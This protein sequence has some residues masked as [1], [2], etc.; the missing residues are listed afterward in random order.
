MLLLPARGIDSDALTNSQ[1][2]PPTTT[3]VAA[4]AATAGTT[5]TVAAAAAPTWWKPS[6]TLAFN[7]QLGEDFDVNRHVIPGV[8][9]YAIDWETPAT[10]VAAMLARG[11]KPI[12][13]F[14][15]GT[16]EDWRPDKADFPPQVIGNALDEWPGESWLD[17]R[18]DAVRAIMAKVSCVVVCFV[19]CVCLLLHN[20]N[21]QH[22]A[23]V[24]TN[25]NT[26][27]TPPK[28]TTTTKRIAACK[29]KGFVAVDPDSVD[30]Y[31]NDPGFPLTAAD[32]LAYNRW[33]ADAAHAAGLAAGL[34]NALDLI[35]PAVAAK[36]DF[37]VNEQCFQYNECGAYA[38]FKAARKPV[39]NIEYARASSTAV[40][41][42]KTR[43]CPQTARFGVRSVLKTLALKAKPRTPCP[44]QP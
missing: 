40:T 15:A 25:T 36:F 28:T 39:F 6:T 21:R 2:T 22:P 37:A 13:Y 41:A 44:G 31:T 34:K 1:S 33:L 35:T 7:Y 5:T 23:T 16:H 14:S 20:S 3:D 27:K 12:C 11:L 24:N 19:C 18:S 30:A 43:L 8:A 26:K 29:A 32:Q 10:T 42:F 9:V 4:A 17:V 38:P